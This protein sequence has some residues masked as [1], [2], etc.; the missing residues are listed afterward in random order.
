[1][2]QL[3][4]MMLVMAGAL[5]RSNNLTLVI[6]PNA[7][8]F[9]T[10]GRR[11]VIPPIAKLM[12]SY[13]DLEDLENYILGAIQ[14]EVGHI[15]FTN[16]PQ[17]AAFHKMYKGHAEFETVRTIGQIIEDVVIE[18]AQIESYAGAERRFLKLWHLLFRRHKA[19]SDDYPV[20][21]LVVDYIFYRARHS[22]LKADFTQ[23]AVA[24]A[25]AVLQCK[26]SIESFLD[27]DYVL[28]DIDMLAS[29]EDGSKLSMKLLSLLNIEPVEQPNQQEQPDSQLGEEEHGEDGSTDLA[30]TENG[31]KKSVEDAEAPTEVGTAD[32]DLV[33]SDPLDLIGAAV[34]AMMGE[35]P[36]GTPVFLNIPGQGAGEGLDNSPVNANNACGIDLQVRVQ[37]HT[38]RVSAR[39]SALLKAQSESQTTYGRSGKI[40]ASRL[41][42]LKMGN[43]KVFRRTV[44]GE[45]LNTSISL[46]MDT[47]GSMNKGI[48]DAVEAACFLPMALEGVDGIHTAIYR[49]PGREYASECLKGFDQRITGCLNELASI[50]ASGGT[51]LSAALQITG[52]DLMEQSSNRKLLV[53]ITDGQPDNE[54]RAKAELNKLVTSGVEIIGIGIDEDLSHLI[55]DFVRIKNV[56]ELTQTICGLMEKKLLAQSVVA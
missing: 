49:F 31:E 41:W 2:S 43:C 28:G 29:T 35:C 47:S 7:T 55:R 14:H 24:E 15:R 42:K 17:R 9:S 54:E 11:L 19:R 25:K 56:E 13:P 18:R 51:P 34:I 16:R 21:G 27:F 3:T 46:L 6:D 20:S 52:A 36:D 8:T 39:L 4:T 44:E 5:A 48:A 1:M 45:S 40:V 30:P 10:D 26:L 33:S 53:V 50:R 32:V 22:V 12:Q 37:Q 23:V 38:M